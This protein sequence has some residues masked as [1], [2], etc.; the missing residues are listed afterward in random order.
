VIIN[1]TYEDAIQCASA[2]S[3]FTESSGI[4]INEK[5][6]T[7]IRLF[8]KTAGELSTITSFDF[9]G[10]TFTPSAL[11]VSPRGVDYI[12][13]RCSK[14]IYNNL[15]LYPRKTGKI[16]KRRIGVGFVDWDLVT[17]LNELRRYIYGGL[18]REQI[19]D[20]LADTINIRAGSGA[21]SYYCLVESGSTFR[22]LDGWLVNAVCR[23]H[24]ERRKIATKLKLKLPK[25]GKLSVLNGSWYTYPPI[26]I[27]LR[28]P[29]FHSAWRAARK[30]WERHGLGS[31]VSGP[32]GYGYV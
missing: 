3:R 7:G 18:S 12:K 15:L 10:Y 6:S 22:Q 16:N 31:I 32:G 25:I 29:S 4:S 17:C 14:I 19:D 28:L 24:T 11:E 13:R 20:Y 2:F 5:K 30:T 27:D 8:A 1:Y 9:L 23:A 21:V 26:P